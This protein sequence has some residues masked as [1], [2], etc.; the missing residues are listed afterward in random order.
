MTQ[1]TDY[2]YDDDIAAGIAESVLRTWFLAEWSRN[3][4]IPA[5]GQ[6]IL[7]SVAHP[8]RLYGQAALLFKGHRDFFTWDKSAMAAG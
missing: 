3:L 5:M 1:C 6:E 8:D 2:D 7:F 4:S